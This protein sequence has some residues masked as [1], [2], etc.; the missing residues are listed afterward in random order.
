MHVK[1]DFMFSCITA[2]ND[3]DDDDD[4]IGYDIITTSSCRH[5]V[6]TRPRV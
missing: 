2:E 1:L 6:E 5:G 4:D 3:D